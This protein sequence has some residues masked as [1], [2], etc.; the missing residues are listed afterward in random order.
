PTLEPPLDTKN[1]LIRAV[2]F[3][4]YNTLI[5]ETGFDDCL[6]KLADTIGVSL[7]AYLALRQNTLQGAIEGRFATAEDRTRAILAGL[8]RTTGDGLDKRVTDL[9]REWRLTR[10]RIFPATLPT[11]R[12]LRERK[13]PIGLVSDCSELMG[14]AVLD[15]LELFPL[16]DAVALSYEVGWA[17]PAREIYDRAI[18]LLG[19]D[20]TECL[21]VGDGG[22][23]E[24]AGARAIGMTTARIDQDGAEGR[25]HFPSPADY[26]IVRLD[27]IFELPALNP[28]SSGHAPL[29]VAWVTRDLA[30]GGRVNPANL[31][32][33][34]MMG[35]DSIVDLRVEES[36][37]PDILAANELRFLHLPM[38]DGD[39]LTQEQLAEGSRWVATERAE[40]RRVLV[41]CQHGV[42]R[43]V[44][45]V[46]ATLMDGGMGARE[47]LDYIKTRRPKIAFSPGQL[48]A[49]YEYA[50]SR[51]L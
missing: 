36:D 31:P 24:I 12:T 38:T 7:E 44:M 17:K 25:N 26:V 49:V 37:D 23:D 18:S 4:L 28:S 39:P 8:G 34:K 5:H 47:A 19:V 41:H 2:I 6:Q 42:G 27:E 9:E 29:D 13:I 32:R 43:S 14:R 51:R 11:L 20:P 22:S 10:V 45:L 46:A 33:L 50:R 48:A 30:V 21:F 15:R 40:G 3:D 1:R 35:I 16:L